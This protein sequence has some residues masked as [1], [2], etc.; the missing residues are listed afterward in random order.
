MALANWFGSRGLRDRFGVLEILCNPM[1]LARVS[2]NTLT[3]T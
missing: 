3:S 2:I 1:F